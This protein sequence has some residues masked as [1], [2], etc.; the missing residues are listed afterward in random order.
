MTEADNGF[1]LA[2]LKEPSAAISFDVGPSAAVSY[3]DPEPHK[4]VTLENFIA[5]AS[6]CD[7]ADLWMEMNGRTAGDLLTLLQDLKQ[8]CAAD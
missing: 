3:G 5:W 7:E 2:P 4:P 1:D 8:R 6:E